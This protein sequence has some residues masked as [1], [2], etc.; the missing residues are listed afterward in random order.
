MA[1]SGKLYTTPQTNIVITEAFERI[2]SVGDLIT[3]QQIQS[4]L[5]S[6]NFILSSWANRGWNLFTTR[7][8]M[9][10][11]VNNQNSYSLP[12]GIT[13]IL[14]ASMRTYVRPLNGTAVEEAGVGGIAANAFDN[15]PATACTQTSPNGWLGYSWTLDFIN[16]QP[17][18]IYMVGVQ[19][20][21]DREYTLSCEYTT[22]SL[23]TDPWTLS[24]SIPKQLYQKG[25]IVWFVIPSPASSK[26]FRIRE[27]GGQ[28]LDIQELYFTNQIN[29]SLMSRLSHQEYMSTTNK[30]INSKPNSYYVDRQINPILYI[31]PV[32]G[33][34][35]S[36]PLP[37]PPSQ[38]NNLFFS[39]K[40]AIQDIGVLLNQ[41]QVPQRFLDALCAELA[42]RLAI[43]YAPDKAALLQPLAQEAF[44]IAREEDTERVPFRIYGDHTGGWTDV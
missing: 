30:Y 31:Y 9:L 18:T 42:Y 44:E 24:L 23:L 28:Q 25:V 41:A 5:N 40:E 29:D 32:P 1:T 15:N 14:E 2:G 22:S 3:A 7:Y 33:V 36:S 38:Y 27:T 8:A 6:L 43:K 34:V 10:Y 17:Q 21:I 11:L 39:Y 35:A 16:F 26:S 13:D 37:N 4:G 19:S 20:N 12:D